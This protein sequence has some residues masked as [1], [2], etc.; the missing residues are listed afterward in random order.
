MTTLA[1]AIHK[2]KKLAQKTQARVYVVFDPAY[3]DEPPDRSYYAATEEETDTFFA[4]CE[5]VDAVE[6]RDMVP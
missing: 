1:N 6:P 2:A 5:I 4:G 3:L